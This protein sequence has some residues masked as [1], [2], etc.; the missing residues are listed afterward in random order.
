MMDAG[1]QMILHAG[2]HCSPFSLMPF[3]DASIPVVS[4]FG[5][6]D[7]DREGMLAQAAS[8]IAVEIYESPHSVDVSGTRLLLVHD[9]AEVSEL[10]LNAHGIVVH[11]HTHSQ[12]MKTRGDTLIV[13]PGE[14]CGWMYGAPSAALLDLD[15]RRVE[16]IKLPVADWKR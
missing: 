5:R 13:N 7:G 6:N 2:D 8:G 10:S 11:G 9:I 4:V 3:L 1:A 15:S 16:F 14:G 12:E